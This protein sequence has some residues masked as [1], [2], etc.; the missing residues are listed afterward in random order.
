MK[1]ILGKIGTWIFCLLLGVTVA[2]GELSPEV[3]RDLQ[4]EA[5]E[6]LR[7]KVS[8]VTSKPAGI[9]DRS[10]WT[11]TIEATV[12]EVVRSKSGV[13]KGEVISIVYH[14]L[15][16]KK[17]WVGPS[18]PPRLKEGNEYPAFLK[19]DE[20]QR[21]SIAARGMSFTRIK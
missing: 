16:P 4:K 5:E 19:R 1:E 13:K 6:E 11:E 20:G 9:F 2:K 21:F 17:G 12:V 15:V 10:N 3:Y 18:P 8:K 7:I 14:R